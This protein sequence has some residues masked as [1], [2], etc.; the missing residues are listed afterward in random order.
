MKMRRIE[1]PSTVYC[2]CLNCNKPAKWI[3]AADPMG[4]YWYC[5]EHRPLTDDEA[6]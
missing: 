5:D 1:D 3:I 2:Q 4:I 6:E